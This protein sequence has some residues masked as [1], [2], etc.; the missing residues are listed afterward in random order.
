MKIHNI[1]IKDFLLP[2][3]VQT[4]TWV[5]SEGDGCKQYLIPIRK[6]EG[7]HVRDNEWMIKPSS[8]GRPILQANVDTVAGLIILLSS[9]DLP[10]KLLG[11]ILVLS[12]D[13][14]LVS[15]G[16]ARFED[17]VFEEALFIAQADSVFEVW[18][19]SG[20][21]SNIL[22]DKN[23]ELISSDF[24]DFPERSLK[25]LPLF[26]NSAGLRKWNDADKTEEQESKG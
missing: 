9:F 18:Y 13:V 17:S 5:G 4:C 7:E 12:G 10:G 23:Y 20:R 3:G 24:Y 8:T 14:K 6:P 22:V 26:L 11:R 21:N 25:A 16:V 1:R 15:N 19:T 2:Y